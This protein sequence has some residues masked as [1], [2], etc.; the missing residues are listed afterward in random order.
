MKS[1]K[2]TDRFIM[3]TCMLAAGVCLLGMLSMTP[4]F[5]EKT[6]VFFNN[7]TVQQLNNSILSTTKKI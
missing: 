4:V 3:R 1:K 7:S 5:G 2:S 6:P